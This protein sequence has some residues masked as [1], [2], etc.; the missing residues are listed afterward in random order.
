MRALLLREMRMLLTSTSTW[1]VTLAMVFTPGL[2]F[3]INLDQYWEWDVSSLIDFMNFLLILLVPAL[4][5]STV[6]GEREK[7]T[8]LLLRSDPVTPG[9][10][11]MAKYF[12]L[13]FFYICLVSMT[14]G[15]AIYFIAEAGGEFD[16]SRQ[17]GA[18]LAHILLAAWYMAL[19]FMCSAHAKTQVG[20]F[21]STF[22]IIL[23]FFLTG[24]IGAK[25]GRWGYL[26]AL[27]TH[28]TS[29]SMGLIR[30]TDIFYFVSGIM[31]CLL[32][33][34]RFLSLEVKSRLPLLWKVIPIPLWVLLWVCVQALM[35]PV[36][37]TWDFSRIGITQPG[38]E[39]LIR[40]EEAAAN[41]TI[42]SLW[43]SHDDLVTV[44]E[45][46]LD[47]M[48]A[49]LPRL[50]VQHYRL[51]RDTLA[52]NEILQ[53]FHIDGDRI[54]HPGGLLLVR[55][56]ERVYL[57]ESDLIKRE[58]SPGRK[59]FRRWQGEFRIVKGIL[60][61]FQNRLGK[62]AIL[63][64]AGSEK[65]NRAE[66]VGINFT[67]VRKMGLEVK[68][69]VTIDQLDPRVYPLTFF[70]NPRE[71]WGE[72]LILKLN[73]Y[74]Q[75]GGKLVVLLE[76]DG[77]LEN[78]H[79]KGAKVLNEGLSRRNP[80]LVVAR[81]P[82]RL[83]KAVADYP[84]GFL[85]PIVLKE[86]A[87]E[88]FFRDRKNNLPLSVTLKSGLTIVGDVDWI[89][90]STCETAIFNTAALQYLVEYLLGQDA[91][92]YTHA[93]DLNV[94][95]EKMSNEA[96]NDLELWLLYILPA[97]LVSIGLGLGLWRRFR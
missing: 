70:P 93:K 6:A 83:R 54:K 30:F 91:H 51:E 68:P 64:A 69:S 22:V 86:G 15:T 29:F 55:G 62:V 17:L 87:G 5:M 80:G 82:E 12:V 20:A 94:K 18:Y 42:I 44:V 56:N 65:E 10:I 61:L 9:Q 41:T 72:E 2:K 35:M 95:I 77:Y 84:I 14:I 13:L 79:Y 57:A 90:R 60:D 67:A 46:Y 19:S 47:N 58:Q 92:H 45:G 75:G 53:R 74:M 32:L 7:G 28:I 71:A 52:I 4:T 31:L 89:R 38:K 36:N 39:A 48:K 1:V 66:E 11:V 97:L 73:Q 88:V 25:L 85:T 21:F 34:G 78:T 37:K 76:P 81:L 59:K 27:D 49:A 33:S 23:A 3:L 16:A 40:V 8:W 50:E 26:L 24:E 63:R 43:S 96:R